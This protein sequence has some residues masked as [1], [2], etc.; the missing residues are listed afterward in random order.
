MYHG[1]RRLLL[2]LPQRAPELGICR[3]ASEL[4]DHFLDHDSGNHLSVLVYQ[5]AQPGQGEVG[6]TARK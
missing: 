3:I 5:V 6:V 1:V 2:A 4:G